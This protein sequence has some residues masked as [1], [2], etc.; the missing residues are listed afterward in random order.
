MVEIECARRML[1]LFSE[2]T[3]NTLNQREENQEK[4]MDNTSI[5][6][7]I[8]KQVEF[9]FSDSNLPRDK[10]L[11]SIVA[12][13]ER[14]YVPIETISN[15][16][17]M[18]QITEDIATIVSALKKSEMLQVDETEKLVRRVT[19]LPMEDILDRRSI[20]VVCL[21]FSIHLSLYSISHTFT[22]LTITERITK[23]FFHN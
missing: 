13:D 6:D 7:K 16:K 10:F 12:N 19:P 1:H 9:Y 20:Y 2:T 5:E 18:K 4:N 15:F 14:G 3:K 17:R 8:L 22:L 21:L 23:R 11:R